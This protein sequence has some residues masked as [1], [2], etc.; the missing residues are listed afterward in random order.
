MSL[1]TDSSQTSSAAIGT[2][3]TPSQTP[4]SSSSSSVP[5]IK[6]EDINWDHSFVR[7]L[8]GDSREGGPVRQVILDPNLLFYL[9]SIFPSTLLWL[10]L[11]LPHIVCFLRQ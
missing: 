11:S 2:S 10:D 5:R 6:L 3:M 1:T 7:E 8:P 4:P 9:L